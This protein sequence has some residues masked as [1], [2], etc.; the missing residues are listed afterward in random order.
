MTATK[1]NAQEEL[2]AKTRCAQCVRSGRDRVVP[3]F[4]F[5][6][7]AANGKPWRVPE[8]PAR[9]RRRSALA[10]RRFRQQRAIQLN[11]KWRQDAFD[12]GA[13][14]AAV[15]DA[16][17]QVADFDIKRN[18]PERVEQLRCFLRRLSLPDDHSVPPA[19]VSLAEREGVLECEWKD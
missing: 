18:V 10:R 1:K 7:T 19:I 2:V 5:F 12:V 4:L 14:L 3:A 15:R 9:S 6:K 11:L 8:R 17:V 16:G 13:A